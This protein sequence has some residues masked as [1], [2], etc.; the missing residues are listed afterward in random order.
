MIARIATACVASVAAAWAAEQIPVSGLHGAYRHGQIFLTWAEGALPA[1]ATLTVHSHSEPITAANLA[2]ARRLAGQIDQHS[3]RDW[4]QDPASFSRDAEPGTPVGWMIAEGATPLDP[5]GGLHVHTVTPDTAGPRYYAVTWSGND[6]SEPQTIVPGVNAMEAPILGVVAPAQ[7]IWQGAGESLP[8]ADSCRG[9]RLVLSLHGRGGGATAGPR[10]STANCLWFGDATQGWR[11]G[12]AFKFA[13]TLQ[14]DTVL[15]TPLDRAWIGR[16]VTESKDQRDHCAAINTWWFGYNQSIRTTTQTDPVIAPNYSERYLLGLVRWAQTHLGC[17]PA[18]TYVRGGSMGGSGA[19]ALALHFPD[20]FAAVHAL[21][22]VYS[23]TRPGQGSATRLECA[24]G[25]LAGVRTATTGG[26]PVLEYFDGAANLRNAKAD[27]PP[28]FATNGRKDGSIPWENNPPFYAAAAA[29]RQ[30]FA[31]YWNDGDHGMSETA[32]EDVK[33]WASVLYRYRLDASYPAFSECSDDRRYGNGHA[34]DGDPEGWVNRGLAWDHLEDTPDRFSLTVRADYPGIAYPIT[35]AV[36][37][38]R[39][40]RFQVR[41][42]ETLSVAIGEEAPR[43]LAVEP[44][45]R[46]TV[47][48]IQILDAAGTHIA[49]RRQ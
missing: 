29:T 22:P 3:A 47:R 17:D 2:Q 6:D 4:W 46:F 10:A 31:V 20:V 19:V 37:P 14:P 25:P 1:G 8:A 33:R 35:V 36:T 40:Q 12:L 43:E 32:P 9:R 13:L 24:C 28:I 15:V 11:E 21:V 44:A 38:R 7:P 30:A 23:C 45:G 34:T 41:P 18:A 39:L 49:I 27:T 26:I 5:S 48:G 16:P 42:G